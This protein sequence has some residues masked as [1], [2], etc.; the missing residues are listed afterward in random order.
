MDTNVD[1]KRSTVILESPTKKKCSVT[2]W[3]AKA[4][5]IN[6]ISMFTSCTIDFNCIQT[7]TK[8]KKQIIKLLK[9]RKI[10]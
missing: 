1:R 9:F 3:G 7:S 5:L 10:H 4:P 2:F 8:K 6:N